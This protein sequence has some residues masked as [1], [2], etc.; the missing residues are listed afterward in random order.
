MINLYVD[1]EHCLSIEQL[2]RYFENLSEGTD[3]YLDLLD[4]AK[5]GDLSK[6][7]HEHGE[8]QLAE[9]VN[10]IDT[11]I[12]DSEYMNVLSE[13][14]GSTSSLSKPPFSDCFLVGKTDYEVTDNQVRISFP[15]TILKSINEN[16][17]I[18]IE[19]PWDKKSDNVNTFNHMAGEVMQKIFN[20]SAMPDN[21]ISDIRIIIEGL[22]YCCFKVYPRYGDFN[23]LMWIEHEHVNTPNSEI[24]FFD[25]EGRKIF[26]THSA[27][28]KLMSIAGNYDLEA[29]GYKLVY[30][31][32]ANTI[33]FI[34]NKGIQTLCEWDSK[35][36]DSLFCHSEYCVG[37]L[38]IFSIRDAKE[39][40]RR[41]V[42]DKGICVDAEE[43]ELD[44]CKK[45]DIPY[46]LG[47]GDPNS[48]PKSVYNS[49]EIS[50]GG[51]NRVEY[52]YESKGEAIFLATNNSSERRLINNNG[53]FKG[54][55]PYN[56]MVTPTLDKSM[57]IATNYGHK[58][59]MCIL[60]SNENLQETYRIK[61]DVQPI[62]F[63]ETATSITI[64]SSV[65]YLKNQD[66]KPMIH[67]TRI[68]DFFYVKDG[69]FRPKNWDPDN[70]TPELY[71]TSKDQKL[72]RIESIYG[73]QNCYFID[74]GYGY[75]AVM[76]AGTKDETI[77]VAPSG[78]IV[79]SLKEGE[80]VYQKVTGSYYL[81]C[82]FGISEG[83]FI[84]KENR[85][86]VYK[87]LSYDG[88]EICRF[89]TNEYITHG[90]HAGRIVYHND[91][92]IGYFD[93]QGVNHTIPWK[94][95]VFIDSIRVLTNGNIIVKYKS[96]GLDKWE[97]ID[98]NGRV[99]LASKSEIHLML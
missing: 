11:T 99:I 86:K 98:I 56:G 3:I 22:E 95:N 15:I 28:E 76:K 30:C 4:Y 23:Q 13:I 61:G 7:L 12:G 19:S 94:K 24:E 90:F 27:S 43:Y 31:K 57:Y 69:E 35:K 2:K 58:Y 5:Y 26:L 47:L 38:S 1:K 73:F 9:N 29:L 33:Y 72:F 63:N 39:R 8:D 80:T 70:C 32:N 62:I 18:T 89:Y 21:R 83:A 84:V 93:D 51:Y 71:L 48:F 92:N 55:H 17:Q 87:V 65:K 59:K 52:I 34:S 82:G 41:F 77:I 75:I 10:E 20:L 91:T 85:S 49:S 66:E 64:S 36:N 44:F 74:L 40:T 14:F 45:N 37:H 60:I 97:L 88:S 96:H 68:N 53:E 50:P 6:W 16:Y 42:I 78:D 81:N 67:Y 25:T 46:T 54:F 79:Y